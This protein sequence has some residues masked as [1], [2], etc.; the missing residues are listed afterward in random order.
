MAV[1]FDSTSKERRRLMTQ[2]YDYVFRPW[3]IDGDRRI[4]AS[5]EEWQRVRAFARKNGAAWI[6]VPVDVF[7]DWK[8]RMMD[9]NGH[10]MFDC[11]QCHHWWSADMTDYDPTKRDS[12]PICQ[13][14]KSPGPNEM[15][16]SDVRRR[17][18]ALI[19][20]YPSV[21]WMLETSHPENVAVM[22]PRLW[23]CEACNSP[24]AE[25]HNGCPKC[26]AGAV[27]LK[28]RPNLWLYAKVNTQS[29]ADA[30]IPHLP[31]FLVAGCGVVMEPREPI[32]LVD[33]K[34]DRHTRMNVLEGVGHSSRSQAQSMS[35]ATCKPVDHVIIRGG[36]EP[37]HPDHV[38]SIIRQCQAAGVPVWCESLVDGREWN[39][40]PEDRS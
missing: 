21:T 37:M 9:S 17:T 3:R 36:D 23:E 5:E 38:R 1:P 40:L 31:H 25:Y 2:L 19:D 27:V 35:N 14:C 8:R 39:Q 7:G 4:V 30:R 15:T 16:M 29:E 32:S 11:C 10:D 22:M 24:F 6:R 28:T 34:F 13:K 33:V 12:R 26:E 18:F 20:D